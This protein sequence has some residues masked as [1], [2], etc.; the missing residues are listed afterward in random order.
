MT[1]FIHGYIKNDIKNVNDPEQ[2]CSYVRT[3]LEFL[4][5]VTELGLNVDPEMAKFFIEEASVFGKSRGT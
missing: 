3:I 1:K 4:N 5:L 2:I